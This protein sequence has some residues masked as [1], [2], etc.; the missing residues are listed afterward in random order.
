MSPRIIVS[1]SRIDFGTVARC[2][3]LATA[4]ALGAGC[5]A[6][7]ENTGDVADPSAPADLVLRGGAVYTMDPEWPWASAVAV[8]GERIVWIGESDEASRWIG[9]ATRVIELTGEMVLPGFHDAHVHPISGGIELRECDLNG[10]DTAAAVLAAV[11]ACAERTP[12][13]E[14]VRGGGWDLPLF[15]GANPQREALDEIAPGRPV[16]LSAADGHSAWV[17]SRALELAGVTAATPDPPNGR[18]ERQPGSGEPSGT[19]RESAMGLVSRLLPAHDDE[20]R[21]AGLRRAVEMAN[22]FGITSWLE[23]SASERSL[24]AYRALD[25]AGELTVRTSVA[26]EVDLD[27]GAGQIDRL[28]DLSQRYRG[29]H[30]RVQTAKIFADGVI[31]AQTAAL[32]EPYAGTGDRGDANLGPEELTELVTALDAASFQVHVHAIGD[33]A[34]RDALD[35]FAAA[36]AANGRRDARHTLTHIQLFD[37]AD[38]PRLAELE[39]AAAFQP[40]WAYAD[41]YI[42]ELTEPVLGPERSRWLYPIR[43]VADAGATL[44]CGSD[45]SVTSMDP[46]LGIEVGVTRLRPEPQASGAAAPATTDAGPTAA[47]AATDTNPVTAGA[48]ASETAASSGASTAAASPASTQS[49]AEA[50]IPEE[51]VDLHTMLA[52]YTTG[53]AWSLFQEDETGSLTAGKAADLIVLDRNL[54]ELPPEQI[55]D[56]RVVLTLLAG[57]EVYRAR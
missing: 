27:A 49:E 3:L 47:G 48:V 6:L 2:V 17:S 5:G 18:I 14:W 19:L 4:V 38:I 26:I 25:D 36:R 55:G 40:L 34:I 53:A 39:V 35:A 23:A 31:E 54:F 46:L 57:R 41:T 43:S 50:W 15:P 11:R 8:A 21:R 16:F 56:A 20:D 24:A 32:L 22:G 1:S 45:W 29:G 28:R 44:A 12:L 13:G 42:T 33:R 51:R 30:V 52:C 10:L 9:P 37:P 7:G